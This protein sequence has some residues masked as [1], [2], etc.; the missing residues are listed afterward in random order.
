MTVFSSGSFPPVGFR[1]TTLLTAALPIVATHRNPSTF[2]D[3]DTSTEISAVSTS[4]TRKPC[5]AS[6]SLNSCSIK[7][8]SAAPILERFLTD[9]EIERDGAAELAIFPASSCTLSPHRPMLARVSRA[10]VVEAKQRRK[11]KNRMLIRRDSR[12]DLKDSS[13]SLFGHFSTSKEPARRL[14]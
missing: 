9:R 8:A 14:G 6:S 10:L 13:A 11:N 2:S 1:I 5:A 4:G 12:I 7:P 3:K